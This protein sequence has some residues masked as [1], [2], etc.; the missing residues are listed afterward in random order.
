MHLSCLSHWATQQSRNVQGHATPTCWGQAQDEGRSPAAAVF[1]L[2]GATGQSRPPLVTLAI[3]SVLLRPG[4]RRRCRAHTTNT[5]GRLPDSFSAIFQLSFPFGWR[6]A[7]VQGASAAAPPPRRQLPAGKRRSPPH[8]LPEHR[9]VRA[10][11]GG[12]VPPGAGPG[13]WG[14]LSSSS[15]TFIYHHHNHHL[16]ALRPCPFSVLSDCLGST[17]LPVPGRPPVGLPGDAWRLCGRVGD[18]GSQLGRIPARGPPLQPPMHGLPGRNSTR[19]FAFPPSTKV[20]TAPPAAVGFAFPRPHSTA[21]A[22]FAVSGCIV[23]IVICC[24]M[25]MHSELYHFIIALS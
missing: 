3:H 23:A 12:Q 11:L 21:W 18:A 8:W 6:R 7:Q 22:Q 15:C 19:E 2:Q 17:C 20:A 4:N 9:Q 14:R 5:T 1:C 24:A 13:W 10:A 16:D 25:H